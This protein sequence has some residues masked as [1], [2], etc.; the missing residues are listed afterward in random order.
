MITVVAALIYKEQKML[1]AKRATGNKEVLGK[2]EFP[3][4]KVESGETEKKAIEREIKEEFDLQIKAQE[5]II[6]N[7]Y[8]YPTKTVNLI[9]YK[10]QFIQ[11]EC[12]LKD[13][14]E[15]KWVNPQDLLDYDLAPADIALAEFVVNENRNYWFVNLG[16]F[17]REQ[18]KGNFLWA[19]MKNKKGQKEHTWE[20]LNLVNKK[21]I[22]LCNNKGKL[23]AVA[24]A[25]KSAYP[26]SIPNYFGHSWNKEGR[27]I[28]VYFVDITPP[29]K[30]IEYKDHIQKN[31][32]P[33][34]NPFDKNGNAKMGYLFEIDKNIAKY[35][36]AKTKNKQI[37]SI[38]QNSEDQFE[39]MKEEKEQFEQ[40]N[41]GLITSYSK[42][43]I[44]QLDQ[45]KY[46]YAPT[47]SLKNQ[48]IKTDP[49]LKATR[50]EWAHY[51]CE[52]DPQHRTFLNKTGQHQY[53]ECHHIIPMNAQKNF[54]ETKLDSMFNLISLCPICHAKVHHA[55][56]KEK[57]DIFYKMF[58][59]R[60][61]EMI[62]K[63]FDQVTMKAILKKYYK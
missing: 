60:E 26:A 30:F 58:R 4:G 5:Y 17:Y 56:L 20:N 8:Q 11:G 9:L 59:I 50:L 23:V 33:Q 25:K 49:K 2:W 31:I 27:K 39:E 61:K 57:E 28:D 13:H 40:I 21:D 29:I 24:I 53:M 3:G 45:E 12:K 54:K 62:K 10:C 44:A 47:L 32:N 35:L 14:Q 6:N 51:L 38:I 55:S 18:R 34:K 63:G 48:R 41:N 43:E 16:K 36:L 15:Y 42:D 37:L 22:I 19:P 7:I 46:M 52:I 1:L